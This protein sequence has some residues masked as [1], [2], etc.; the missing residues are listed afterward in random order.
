MVSSVVED[1]FNHRILD[2]ISNFR[3]HPLQRLIKI[4]L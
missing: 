1:D 3:L 2:A 4:F